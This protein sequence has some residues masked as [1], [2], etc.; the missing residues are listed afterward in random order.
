MS[1]IRSFCDQLHRRKRAMAARPNRPTGILLLSSGGLGDTI[2][3]SIIAPY[4]AMLA[5]KDERITLVMQHSS[6]ASEFLFPDTFEILPLNYRKFIRQPIYRYNFIDKIFSRNFRLAVSTDHLRLPTV[7]DSLI[8]AADAQLSFALRP[9]SWPKHDKLLLE[10]RSIYTDWIET[11]IGM[12]HRMTRWTELASALLEQDIQI[13]KIRFNQKL[14]PALEKSDTNYIIFHP[15]SNEAERNFS[16]TVWLQLAK[17]LG[18]DHEII[19]SVGP[20]DLEKYPEFVPLTRLPEIR[21]NTEE[22]RKKLTLFRNAQLIITVDTSIL[23]LAV[24][25][26]ART[27]CLASAAHT[28]DSIPYDERICPDNVTFL[29]EELPCAGCLGNCIHPLVNK[30]YLCVNAITPENAVDK[31]LEIL[32]S[33]NTFKR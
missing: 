15:F 28:V 1:I 25:C 19:L 8:M 14:M 9:R 11:A 18:K 21:T 30:R 32:H 23:H 10:H 7:D 31:A 13:P 3:F 16:L 20:G 17:V 22:L 5:L 2:L 27:L 6:A 12:S 4:F 29:F 26:G 33:T 24:G